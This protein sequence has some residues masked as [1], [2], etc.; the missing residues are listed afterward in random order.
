ML[1]QSARNCVLIVAAC[2]VLVG[3]SDADAE[4]QLELAKE[5]VEAALAAWKRGETADALKTQPTPIEFHDDD[6]QRAARLLD[7]KLVQTY[8]DTDGAPRCATILTVEQ[9]GGKPASM[10][11]TYHVITEPKIVIARD[12]YS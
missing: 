8:R 4:R 5:S 12:P 9:R 1:G 10:E 7:Y 3:C 6:W 11:V 2:S